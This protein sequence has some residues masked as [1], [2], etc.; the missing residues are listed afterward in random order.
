MEEAKKARS[1]TG[2]AFTQWRTPVLCQFVHTKQTLFAPMRSVSNKLEF[3]QLGFAI[4]SGQPLAV[5]MLL[6][7]PS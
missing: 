1:A 5:A 6:L 4:D 3:S 2:W 7:L